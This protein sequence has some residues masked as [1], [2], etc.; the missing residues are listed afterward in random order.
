MNIIKQIGALLS[1][2]LLQISVTHCSSAQNLE[3]ELPVT[4][5]DV[6][7]QSWVA[8]VKG[9]GSG[10]N[11]FIKVQDTLVKLDSIYFRNKRVALEV[12][13]HDRTLYI[14][15][16][17]SGSNQMKEKIMHLEPKEEY[18]NTMPEIP[19]PIPFELKDYECV[20]SFIKGKRIKYF[21]IEN[22]RRERSIPYPSAPLRKQ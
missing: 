4:I 15:R 16:F 1:L 13:P 19:V 22:L 20:I 8:G 11:V 6:Y 3:K 17:N 9:G 5:K 7:Y 10:I 12:K 2:A 21:K 14:G 18:G